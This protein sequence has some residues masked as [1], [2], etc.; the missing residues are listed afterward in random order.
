ME[1]INILE[2]L[3]Y[4]WSRF[5][6]VI[7][8]AIIGFIGSYLYTF[9]LQLPVYRSQTS[10]VLTKN[11]TSST[12]ITQS[13]INLNKNLVSTYRQIVKSRR[14]LDAVIKNLGLQL[15]YNDLNEQVE[16]KGI[17]DTELIVISVY[18]ENNVLAKEIADEIARVFK[19]EITKIY[20]IENVS[21]IDTALVSDE[22]HNVSIIKQF[23]IGTGSGFLIGSLIIFFFFYTDDTIKTEEDIEKKIGLSVLG[24]VPKYRSKR[25]RR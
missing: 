16:V 19:T 22:P 23:V 25:S 11:D 8:F 4:Y 20:S 21:I 1:D 15:T 18:N 2:F 7:T 3:K 9:H 14:I 10:L 12:T 5:I 6:I 17:S 13:D 24:R